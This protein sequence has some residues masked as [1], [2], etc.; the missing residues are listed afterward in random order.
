MELPRVHAYFNQ[1][2]ENK[3]KVK[4]TSSHKFLLLP[5]FPEKNIISS[6]SY[7]LAA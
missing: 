6:Y 5:A 4:M 2:V 3:G 7:N 1:K